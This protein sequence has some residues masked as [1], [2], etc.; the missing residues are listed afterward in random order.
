M[1][2]EEQMESLVLD[3]FSK[4]PARESFFDFLMRV[5]K[6]ARILAA[7]ESVGDNVR[8]ARLFDVLM[9]RNIEITDE[10]YL[11]LRVVGV[12]PSD[13]EFVAAMTR[14]LDAAPPQKPVSE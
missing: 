7:G 3:E 13:E 9:R 8:D 2:T 6:K 14:A 12:P 11:A 10:A 5:A 1:I 4:R